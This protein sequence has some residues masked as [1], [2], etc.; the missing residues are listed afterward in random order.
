MTEEQ[1][2]VRDYAEEI[3]R[4]ITPMREACVKLRKLYEKAIINEGPILK[5][6]FE[7][8]IPGGLA[9]LEEWEKGLC[10]KK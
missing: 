5:D 7:E 9:S 8:A 3:V 1:Q 4:A 6:K 10:L 2:K